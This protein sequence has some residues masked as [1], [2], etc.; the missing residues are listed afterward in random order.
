MKDIARQ[1]NDLLQLL[2]DQ[3]PF[4]P[5]K[6]NTPEVHESLRS[7]NFLG[8]RE[9]RIRKLD[10]SPVLLHDYCLPSVTEVDE[11]YKDIFSLQGTEDSRIVLVN[12][13]F[14]KKYS[15][16]NLKESQVVV[17]PLSE[18]PANEGKLLSQYFNK[19]QAHKDNLFTTL[20][21]AYANRGIFV[22]IK[23]NVSV[24]KPIHIV[25]LIHGNNQKIFLQTRNL[26]IAGKNSCVQIINSYHSISSDFTLNNVVT[27]MFTKPG[28]KIDYHLFQGEGNIA[29]HVHHT[30]V[31]QT[32][33]STLNMSACTLCGQVVHNHIKV[34]LPESHCTTNLRG[35]YIPGKEQAFNYFTDL[36]HI[37]P[38]SESS[39][40]FKGI[41]EDQAQAVF[42]G[43]V[44]VARDAQKTDA[45]QSGKHILLGEKAKAY[46]RPQLEIYA[47][48]VSCAHGSTVGQLNKEALFYLKS[49]GISEKKAQT[50]LLHA[51]TDDI[52][53]DISIES[54]R[55]LLAYLAGRRLK[56]ED[57]QNLCKSDLCA[58]C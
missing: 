31:E 4:L 45:S 14:S 30:R 20:N 26:I 3:T 47:D 22:Y 42:T 33:E 40:V 21:T 52:L 9:Q 7:Q 24:D 8:E 53:R 27:E 10:L 58:V 39:Q 19:T 50:M 38:H 34:H 36:K 29:S 49:R 48:D 6:Q 54:Y 56:G 43:K 35:F 44:Y 28:S 55:E 1:K 11:K 16:L 23:E 46:A 37:A 25:N 12:G 15:R 41:I 5:D 13:H 57:I 32:Q 17:A 51:F 18:V 2:Q